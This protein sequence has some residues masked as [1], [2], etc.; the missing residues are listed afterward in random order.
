MHRYSFLLLLPV[1]ADAAS[2]YS[3]ERTVDQGIQV[4]HLADR[5]RGVE[6]AI[7]PSVG[8]RAYEL[9]AHGKNLLFASLPDSASLKN[10]KP[11]AFD[12]IPFLAPWANRLAGGGF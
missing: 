9:K 12:G 7:A 8:N 10:A 5:A 2:N 6:V 1:I 3:A 11:P 4:V